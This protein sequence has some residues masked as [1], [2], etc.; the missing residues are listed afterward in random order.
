MPRT[1]WLPWNTLSVYVLARRPSG[2]IF[3]LTITRIRHG[4]LR[5]SKRE[6]KIMV[7]LRFMTLYACRFRKKLALVV[8]SHALPRM[9]NG[10]L[11]VSDA[12]FHRELHVDFLRNCRCRVFFLEFG[13]GGDGDKRREA[14]RHK[15]QSYRKNQGERD[16]TSDRRAKRNSF[17][18]LISW[19][20]CRSRRIYN[21][22]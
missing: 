13:R 9:S 15:F 4:L 3:S 8:T 16:W 20:R 2:S 19:T 12:D 1:F 22:H 14:W 17:D 21:G 11:T 5:E 10:N 7:S 6:M 18:R